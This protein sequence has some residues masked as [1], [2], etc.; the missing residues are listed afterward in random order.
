MLI[1]SRCIEQNAYAIKI[2]NQAWKTNTHIPPWVDIES[3]DLDQC[4]TCPVIA[5]Q[6]WTLLDRFMRAEGVE[7]SSYTFIEPSAGL[8]AFYDLLPKNRR[9]GIDV[10]PFRSEYIQSEFLSWRPKKEGYQ[11]I[12]VGNPPFGTR[13]WL[14][15]LFLNHAAQFCD[16]VA[17]ILPM[18]FQNTMK[19]S[20]ATRVQGLNLVHSSILPR[21]SFIRPDGKPLKINTL[22]QIWSRRT[23][24]PKE[25]V[26]TC[27]Q[28]MDLFTINRDPKRPCGQKRIPE[29]HCFIQRL[30]YGQAPKIVLHLDHIK[31]NHCLGIILKRDRA[32]VLDILGSTDWVQYSNLSLNHGR[33]IGIGHVRKAL[34]DKGLFDR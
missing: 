13:A 4:F 14:A 10:V 9:M 8:G 28:Y 23:S 2:R 30:F 26:K 12:C 20:L 29:A 1:H 31:Y 22:W 25:S 7:P 27:H 6:C 33:H 17:F 21:E 19:G 24:I 11:H 32:K 16:Y 18:G 3:V 34:T 15:L 5:R